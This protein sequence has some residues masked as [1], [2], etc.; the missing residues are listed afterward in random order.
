MAQIGL[1][2]ICSLIV[3]F[4]IFLIFIYIKSKFKN[5]PYP[6]FFNI[7]FCL[8]ISLNNI[9]RLIHI[10]NSSED[11]RGEEEPD[12]G[13]K[14]QAIF[15]TVLDKLI[16]DLVCSYSLI[17]YFGICRVEFYKNNEKKIYIILAIISLLI[18]IILAIIFINQG[19]S[20]K[21]AFCYAS[22]SNDVKKITDS[23]ITGLLGITS[24][25][26]LIITLVNIIK[27]KKSKENSD[28]PDRTSDIKFHIYRFCSNICINIALFTYIILI[29]IKKVYINDFGKDL[30]FIL[31]CLIIEIYFTVNKEFI[32]ETKRILTC[33]KVNNEEEVDTKVQDFCDQDN[34]YVEL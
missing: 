21:S 28:M 16:L 13:C 30:I 26:C 11:N 23:I 2:I 24:L 1:I 25:I 8:S 17:N 7:L 19:Y 10:N 29:I 4:N 31:L 3:L 18:S 33:Q 32:K 15:L 14:I 5:N 22:T 27:L 34:K 12:V 6:Y 9:L 20:S